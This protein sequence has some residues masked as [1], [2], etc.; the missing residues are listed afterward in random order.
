MRFCVCSTKLFF[1]LV[2]TWFFVNIEDGIM[3]EK[4]KGKQTIRKYER[5]QP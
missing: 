3:Q 1:S 5:K 4:E 2:L